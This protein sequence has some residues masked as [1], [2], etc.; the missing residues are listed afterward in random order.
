M[1]GS[2]AGGVDVGSSIGGAAGAGCINGGALVACCSFVACL[3]SAGCPPPVS[4]FSFIGCS[5]TT[6]DCS[7]DVAVLVAVCSFVACPPSAGCC[8]LSLAPARDESSAAGCWSLV[9]TGN[10]PTCHTNVSPTESID[11]TLD[12]SNSA[13]TNPP[14]KTEALSGAIY[15]DT[16]SLMTAPVSPHDSGTPCARF[17]PIQVPRQV[18]G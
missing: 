10:T 4:C 17:A 18:P 8:S 11:L 3:S 7:V 1:S 14:Q 2:E 9:T 13:G 15:A 12:A 16:S 5:L 6:G